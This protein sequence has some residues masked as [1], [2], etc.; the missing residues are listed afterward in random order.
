MRFAHKLQPWRT[1]ADFEAMASALDSAPS[2]GCRTPAPAAP[3]SPRR[4]GEVRVRHPAFQVETGDAVLYVAPAGDD[5]DGNVAAS[6][7]HAGTRRRAFAAALAGRTPRGNAGVT[8][9]LRAGTHYLADTAEL[10]ALDSHLTI[11]ALG[12]ET[13]TLSGAVPLGLRRATGRLRRR[14][15]PAEGGVGAAGAQRQG[16]AP[17]ARRGHRHDGDDGLRVGGRRYTR[18]LPERRPRDRWVGSQLLAAGWLPLP[19]RAPPLEILPSRPARRDDDMY[20]QR[21]T[22]GVGGACARFTPAA[23]YW[24][25]R[26]ATIAGG[27]DDDDCR[28]GGGATRSRCRAAPWS[29]APRCRA[30]R[31][32]PP[33]VPAPVLPAGWCS[34]ARMAAVSLGQLDDGTEQHQRAR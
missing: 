10:G 7:A 28:P 31:G 14:P 6:P 20:F 16:G 3:M 4:G 12:N 18:P 30:S 17:C 11:Q 24:C 15:R 21:Y 5:S 26:N 33:P 1:A 34:A 27:G 13:P 22:L 2:A 8:I 9:V 19:A 29:T 23:G 25:A 32:T